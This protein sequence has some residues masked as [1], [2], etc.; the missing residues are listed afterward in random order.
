MPDVKLCEHFM[1]TL[2]VETVLFIGEL[3]SNPIQFYLQL[4][5]LKISHYNPFQYIR[6]RGGVS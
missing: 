6:I 5:S 1:S 2:N 4:L 3:L